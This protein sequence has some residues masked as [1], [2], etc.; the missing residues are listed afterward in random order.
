MCAMGKCDIPVDRWKE[1]MNDLF[2][3]GVNDDN[4]AVIY[5]ANREVKVAIKTPHGLTDR[6]GIK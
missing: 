2:E 1:T 4:L 3:A 6:V 5:E